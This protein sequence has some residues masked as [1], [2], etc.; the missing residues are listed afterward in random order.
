MA[1]KKKSQFGTAWFERPKP[2]KGHV[3]IKKILTKVKNA[4]IRNITDKVDN[5]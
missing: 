1:K 3:D 5:G 4:C 2:K